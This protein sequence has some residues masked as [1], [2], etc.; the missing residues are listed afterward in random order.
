[1]KITDIR[2]RVFPYTAHEKRDVQGH[3]HYAE[4]F[5]S[6]MA[7]LTI[8]ADDGSEGHCIA[9]PETVRPYVVA[10]HFKPILLGQDPFQRERL[11]HEL[12]DAQRSSGGHLTDKNVGVV[13]MALWDLAGRKLGMPVYKLVG[14]Y[15]DRIKAYASTM[16]GDENKGGLST[17]DEYAA[18]AAKLVQRGYKGIK[19]HT[20]NPP[21]SWAPDPKMDARA[22]AAVREAVGP[23]IALMLDPY[24]RYS[25]TDALWLGK[26]I[27]AL[28]FLWYEEPMYEGSMSS[29][30]W[31]SDQLGV[32]V[33]G[34]ETQEGR[35]QV[36]A[37]WAKAGA[38]DMLRTGVSDLG[39]ISGSLKVI[40]LAESFG[41]ECEIHHAGPGAMVLCASS[42]YVNW[43]ERGLLHPMIDYDAVPE[44]LN[45]RFDA[46]GED[47]YIDMPQIPG[48]GFDINFDYIDA[49]LIE[50]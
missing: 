11:W 23:D 39:G 49:N 21:V 1:M 25:R 37:E 22:C 45:S 30:A 48:V 2:V 12:V 42:R 14:S 20:W 28:G 44:Y 46:M 10:R 9:A 4:P 31:L 5:Q 34:P 16:C 29:Y 47:G 17:P 3:Q 38:C 35:H 26:Q 50:R 40:H 7:L 18:F 32:A 15:R 6:Q 41:M 33:Q 43:Y 27:E 36:R 8:V 19:L 24:H 13:E